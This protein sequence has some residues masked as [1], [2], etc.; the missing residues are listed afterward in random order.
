MP[1]RDEDEQVRAK[2]RQEMEQYADYRNYLSFSMFEQVT[3]EQG[4]VIRENFVDDMAGR[5]SGGEGQNRNIVAL[6]AGFAIA[7]HAAETTGIPKSSWY[8]WTRHFPRW[9]RSGVPSV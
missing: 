1:P 3:D 8:F 9:I 4:N 6:L 7:V 2:K 5:D